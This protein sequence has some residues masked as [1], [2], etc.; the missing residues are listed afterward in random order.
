MIDGEKIEY[1]LLK[2]NKKIRGSKVGPNLEVV[3]PK[4]DG[5]F[6]DLRNSRITSIIDNQEK[7]SC[8]ARRTTEHPH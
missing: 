2:N 5:E 8:W 7:I 6:R 1:L 3:I 4:V